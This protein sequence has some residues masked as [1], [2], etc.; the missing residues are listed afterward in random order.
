MSVAVCDR[1]SRYIW[2]DDEEYTATKDGEF[3]CLICEEGV[4]NG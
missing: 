2:T 4:D 1:C 3:V